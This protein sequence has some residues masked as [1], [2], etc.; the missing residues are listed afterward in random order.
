MAE[1]KEGGRSITLRHP[2]IERTFNQIFNMILAESDMG[3]VLI[4]TSVLDNYLRKLFEKVMPSSCAKGT[5][6]SLLNYPG[7]LSSLSAKADVAYAMRLI[8]DSI[9]KS[10]HIL[11]EIRN[12]AAHQPEVFTLDAH[13]HRLKEMYEIAEGFSE[14]VFV[15]SKIYIFQSF[16]DRL[17]VVSQDY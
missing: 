11:R 10:I 6:R 16:F 14:L 17:V 7:P 13:K 2:E 12:K 9:H 8:G 4:S 5:K 1:E 15:M 3:A